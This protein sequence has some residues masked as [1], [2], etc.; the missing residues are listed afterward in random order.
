MSM[1]TAA[2]LKCSA[3]FVG[4]AALAV[5][6]DYDNTSFPVSTNEIKAMHAM[7]AAG[8]TSLSDAIAAAE[9]AAGGKAWSASFAGEN[10]AEVV[11]VAD[12]GTMHTI[13][14]DRETGNVSKDEASQSY[15]YPGDP[16]TGP[17]VETASGLKYFDLKV[18]EGAQP[19]GS[20]STV[21][22]HYS[23]WLVDGTKFDSS[24]DRG[25]PI[26]F[27]LN[28]VIPGWTEGVASMKVGGKR[29]LIIPYTLGYGVRGNPPRIPGKATL[30][31]DVEL[32]DIPGETMGP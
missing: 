32:L 4:A 17:P 11:V 28:G 27:P 26:S 31:F 3:L 24:V 6:A 10:S 8:K 2:I 9:K 5:A 15:E 20:S 18:G 29:K 23:G 14:I 25:Q 22:V 12:N 13:T 16:V 7:A 19:K 30:V 1:T 21:N